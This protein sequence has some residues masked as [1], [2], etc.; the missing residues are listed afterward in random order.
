V[1]RIRRQWP[2]YRFEYFIIWERTQKGWPHA[3]LLLRAPY[4]PQRYLSRVWHDLTG[5]SIVDIRKVGDTAQ[6]ASYVAKYL[7]KDP[8]VPPGM[9]R[10]R[11]SKGFLAS[12]DIVPPHA[13]GRPTNWQLTPATAQAYAQ[14]RSAGG[15]T[16]QGHPDGSYTLYPPWSP[17]KPLYDSLT[18]WAPRA[19]LPA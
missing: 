12:V 17:N 7:A 15:Y 9:K 2:H 1:K 18:L 6:V 8:R 16:A 10:Y 19:K 3:H 11:F 13:P 4:I 14:A 5:A